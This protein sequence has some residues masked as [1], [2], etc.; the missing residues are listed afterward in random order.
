MKLNDITITLLLISVNNKLKKDEKLSHSLNIKM[1]IV[2]KSFI[3][4]SFWTILYYGLSV[5][6]FEVADSDTAAIDLAEDVKW[7]MP[8]H[9]NIIA[10]VFV[11]NLE[12]TLTTYTHATP[13]MHATP[14]KHNKKNGRSICIL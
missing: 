11:P 6:I 9:V 4:N 8:A 14:Q 13:H 10:S 3:N 1:Q 5:T 7:K 12:T 2:N